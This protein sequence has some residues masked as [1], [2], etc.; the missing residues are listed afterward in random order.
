MKVCPKCKTP[1]K[2]ENH[3]CIECGTALGA[4]IGE[5]DEQH[6]LQQ[7]DD[8]LKH[9]MHERYL[10]R[11]YQVGRPEYWIVAVDVLLYL[12][13][14]VLLYLCADSVPHPIFLLL[15]WGLCFIGGVITLFP[16]FTW[17]LVRILL[18]LSSRRYYY[19]DMYDL[20]EPKDGFIIFHRIFRILC[21]V[22][23]LA[24][25]ILAWCPAGF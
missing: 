17:K 11:F 7:A 18:L 9:A 16:M 22:C 24:G 8:R 1:Q 20:E 5:R 21:P 12:V 25:L 14:M 3:H 15:P 2:D 23:G 6:L 13:S 4:P 10:E 19:D